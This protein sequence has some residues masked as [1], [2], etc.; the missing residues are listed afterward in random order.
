MSR[1][2]AIPLGRKASRPA[3]TRRGS[4]A[5][6]AVHRR[7]VMARVGGPGARRSGARFGGRGG[8]GAGGPGGRLGGVER[9]GEGVGGRADRRGGQPALGHPVGWTSVPSALTAANW[10]RRVSGSVVLIDG[11]VTSAPADGRR[12]RRRRRR[13]RRGRP[14]SRLVRP[15]A[16]RA[17]PDERPGVGLRL[18]RPGRLQCRWSGAGSRGWRRCGRPTIPRGR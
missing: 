16:T 2:R 13:A 8:A 18:R 7:A 9:G 11:V 17:R 6:V 12:R 1:G 5:G 3:A 15:P 14:R 4:A 10:I